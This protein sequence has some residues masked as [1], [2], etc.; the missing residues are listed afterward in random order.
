MKTIAL[1]LLSAALLQ[2]NPR[3]TIAKSTIAGG[4]HTPGA[5]FT[6]TGTIGQP[7]A[8]PRFTSSDNRFTLEPGFWSPHSVVQLPDFPPLVMRPGAPGFSVIAWPV[9]ANGFILQSS[10]DMSPGSWMD[11]GTRPVDTALEHTVTVSNLAPRAFFRLRR[12]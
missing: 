5:R 2:A 12:Q 1:L 11:I 7:D 9:A 10:P 8:A 4:A 6:L 3:F